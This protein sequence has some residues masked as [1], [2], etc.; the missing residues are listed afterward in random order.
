MAAIKVMACKKCGYV[1]EEALEECPVCQNKK[2]T[3]FWK[4]SVIVNDP[5]NSVV[6][7]KLNIENKGK[8]ALR[9]N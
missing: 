3:T 2:F 1:V 5:E 9:I 6:A 7:K 4:G 8:Y